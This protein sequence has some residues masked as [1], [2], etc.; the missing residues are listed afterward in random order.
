MNKIF[1]LLFLSLLAFTANAQT[2]L[3]TQPYGEINK[4]DLEMKT[5]DFEKDANA[6]VL[7]D[8]AEIS[9]RFSSIIMQRHKRIKIFN[10]KGKDQASVRVEYL[11]A[12]NDKEISEIDAQTI[13]LNNNVIEYTALDKKLIYTEVVDKNKRA[14]VFTFPNVKAGSVIEFKYKWHTPYPYN[15]PDWYFQKQIPTRYSELQAS[16]NKDYTGKMIRK[17]HQPFYRDT[18]FF[19]NGKNHNQGD[20][21]L[22]ALN[23]VHSIKTEPFMTSMRDN[24]QC[25]LFQISY[26]ERTWLKICNALVNDDDFGKQLSIPLNNE[27]EIL[28]KA[29]E[30]RTDDEKIAYIFNTVKTRIA[31]DNINDFYTYQ[32][33]EKTWNKKKGNSTEINLIICRLLKQAG[34]SAY[35]VIVSTS[36][37]IEA[38]YATTYQLDK[39]VSYIQVD[40]TKQYVLDATDKYNVYNEIPIDLLNSNGLYIDVEKKIYRIM[41]IQ[42]PLP[43]RQNTF[44]N[45]EIK[46]DGKMSGTANIN[47]FSYNRIK[48]IKKYKT[49][50]DKKY[51]DYLKEGDNNLKITSLK[52]E[53]MEVDSL[54]LTQNIAFTLDMPGT[55]ENYI[56][57]NPNL[58]TGLNPNPFLSEERFSDIDFGCLNI[59]TINGRYKIPTGFKVDVLPKSTNTTIADKSIMF[60]RV[61][62]EQDGYII[63]HYIINFKKSLYSKDDYPDIRAFYKKMY[64]MLNEQIVLKKS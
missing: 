39:T 24:V 62:A 26:G 51:T 20:K 21:Y 8:K 47:S 63:V 4:A 12:H 15:Y 40:S 2:V 5:C 13:N 60:K 10:D 38:A 49:D 19:L 3:T 34:L 61:V 53:N 16:F 28:A 43:T 54:P 56:Y 58:F 22:W 9:Y 37:K 35:P 7:F 50:G 31:W 25:I 55:D 33:I 48:S 6:E 27:N 14:M 57:V 17:V 30:L 46:S 45:A 18:S 59:Y 11:G 41:Q 44:V 42:S 23:N 1:A 29:F 36:G 64:E 52:F 32:G